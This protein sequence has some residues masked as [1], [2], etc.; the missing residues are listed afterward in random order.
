M[1]KK[2]L[3]QAK[4]VPENERRQSFR[5]DPPPSLVKEF[6]L[7]FIPAAPERTLMLEELGDPELFSI[8]GTDCV[9][10]ENI[11]AVGIRFSIAKNDLPPV[12]KLK[13]G[14]CYIYLKLRS[15]L[16]GKC[17]LTCLFLGVTLLGASDKD[18]RIHLRGKVTSRGMAAKSSK[19]FLLFNVERVGIK[20]LTVWCEEI[21]RMG[22]GILPPLTPGLDLEYLMIEISMMQREKALVAPVIEDERIEA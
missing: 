9:L 8:N 12:P 15:P 11:S 7:W 2:P 18:G 17:A 10:I 3:S 19:S 21:S 1:L 6:A 20:E 4:N 16:P 13:Q 5:V 14:H 22:R